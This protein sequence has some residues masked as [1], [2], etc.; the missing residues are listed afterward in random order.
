MV[1]IGI[2]AKNQND[3]WSFIDSHCFG[4]IYNKT[5]NCW[6]SKDGSVSYLYLDNPTMQLRGA[7][8][9][10]IYLTDRYYINKPTRDLD[11]IHAILDYLYAK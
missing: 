9:N 4:L 5:K 8:Y 2:I 11:E 10:H 6:E 3:A 7:N 1:V